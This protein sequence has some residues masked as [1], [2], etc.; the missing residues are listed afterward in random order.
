MVRCINADIF[1]TMVEVL[2]NYAYS[3]RS[4][5]SPFDDIMVIPMG[6]KLWK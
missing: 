6:L 1:I 3:E 5:I 2:I 4:D